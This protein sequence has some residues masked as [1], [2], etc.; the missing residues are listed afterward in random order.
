MA[1]AEQGRKS[2]IIKTT[3]ARISALMR[4]LATAE[5]VM[6]RGGVVNVTRFADA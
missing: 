3:V 5:P 6:R 4:G 2:T 1:A